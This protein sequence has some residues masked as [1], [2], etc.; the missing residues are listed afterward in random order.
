VIVGLDYADAARE[1]VLAL[2]FGSR[3]RAALPLAE[4]LGVAVEAA[5]APADLLAA[6]PL[7]RRRERER[8]Y[9]Q[10]L[11]LADAIGRASGI[12]LDAR[13]LERRRH[14]RRQ[15]RL[16]RAARRRGPLGAFV[17]RRPRV[18]GRCVLLVDDVL[19]TGATIRACALALRRAGAA[20]VTAAVACRTP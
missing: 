14:T 6:V 8:G 4:A 19:T 13:A 11:L 12:P 20:T 7:S 9:N 10:A 2:K 16:S 5:G 1:L 3:R 18:S 15:S 17:A